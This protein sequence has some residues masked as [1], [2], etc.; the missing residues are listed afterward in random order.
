MPESQ[1]MK[2]GPRTGGIGGSTW[3]RS[4]TWCKWAKSWRWNGSSQLWWCTQFHSCLPQR[5]ASLTNAG[6]FTLLESCGMG[7][8]SVSC[9]PV[10]AHVLTLATTVPWLDILPSQH[11]QTEIC[12][13][14]ECLLD[15]MG[16]ILL[17][18]NWGF[19]TLMS[20]R[21]YEYD[22]Q[23]VWDVNLSPGKQ[24]CTLTNRN[25][26]RGSMG[27]NYGAGSYTDHMSSADPPSWSVPSPCHYRHTL[28]HMPTSHAHFIHGTVSTENWGTT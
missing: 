2:A 15:L 28:T 24:S 5:S 8:H 11:P 23:K 18:L 19:C 4:W 12:G 26:V 9:I 10:Q 14:W 22:T 7:G 16:F 27:F 25:W 20:P 21:V 13:P 17:P 3:G 6:V 1:G